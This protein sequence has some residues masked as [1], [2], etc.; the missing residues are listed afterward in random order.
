LLIRVLD[1][2]TGQPA[3]CGA[4]VWIRDGSYVDTLR[5]SDCDWP[6]SLQTG[7]VHGA[8]ERPGIYEIFVEKEG[9]RTWHH[10]GVVV[11]RMKCDCHV[12]TRKIDARL[13]PIGDGCDYYNIVLCHGGRYVCG[14]PE[15]AVQTFNPGGPPTAT[16]SV[17]F[18]DAGGS[19]F[20][21]FV[22]GTDDSVDSLLTVGAL[23]AAGARG[24]GIEA[25]RPSGGFFISRLSRDDF[26]IIWEQVWTDGYRFTGFGRVHIKRDLHFGSIDRIRTG[27]CPV[28]QC[29]PECERF[30]ESA[31]ERGYYFPEQVIRFVCR[32][33]EVW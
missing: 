32:G 28:G 1:G 19:E 15:C 18:R 2:A 24:G 20:I 11:L 5:N 29:E 3:A 21:F 31:S 7:W 14:D 17:I 22:R 9:F 16:L 26:A 33:G 30:S 27:G 4:T 10:P 6:D 25:D 23:P 8:D 12:R 13:Q